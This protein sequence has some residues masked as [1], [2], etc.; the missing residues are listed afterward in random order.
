MYGRDVALVHDTGYGDFARDAAPGLLALLRAGAVYDGLV[1]DLG[2]GSGIWAAALLEAGYEVLGIDA[3]GEL[4]EIARRRAPSASFVRGS[5]FDAPLRP[6]AAITSIGECVTYGPDP[7]AGRAAFVA[8]LERIGAA[9]RPGG[10]LVF[11]VVTPGREPRRT[12]NEGEDWVICVDG[13]PDPDAATYRR[14]MTVFRRRGGSGAGGDRWRRSDEV[15]DV[16]LY[17]PED[18][19]ADLRA[20]GFAARELDGYGDRVRFGRG[21]AGFVAARVS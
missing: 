9:L 1:V 7:R 8:L 20:A 18:V 13:R 4:L 2:C 21:H 16:W 3:S 11:D 14:A 12:W 10:V 15:H 17:E 6:C 5:L 19:L